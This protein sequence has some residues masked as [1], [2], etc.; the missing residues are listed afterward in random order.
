VIPA[1]VGEISGA[2]VVGFGGI[3]VIVTP[4][5]PDVGGYNRIKN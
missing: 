3:I 1:P 2:T 5:G 4:D